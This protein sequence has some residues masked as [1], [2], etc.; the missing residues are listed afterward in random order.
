MMNWAR[1]QLANVTGTPEPIYGPSAIRSIATQA[2]TT[3]FTLLEKDDV[4]WVDMES[5]SMET[6]TFYL[7]A[8]SGHIGIVQVIHSNVVGL[9]RTSQFNTKIFYPKNDPKPH[10][11]STDQLFDVG[12]SEDKF[13]FYASNCAI[14]ISENGKQYT[15]KSTSNENSIVNLT[16]SQI[17]PGFQVGKDGKTLYGTNMSSP[18]GSMRHTFWPRNKVEGL[19]VTK[20]GP[21][22]FKGLCLFVHALQGMKPH[23]A[24]AK[25]NFV[26]FQGPKYTA[27]MMEFT[28][29][30]SY[31]STTVN[32]GGIVHDNE[33]TMASASNFISYTKVRCDEDNNW[34]VPESAKYEWIEKTDKGDKVHAVIEGSLGERSDRIDVMA[35]LPVFVKQI[36]AGAVGTKPYIYQFFVENS[37]LR[38]KNGE[39]EIVE[40]GQLFT[41]ATFISE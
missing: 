40:E 31:G 35:E 34:L 36:V 6:Q 38:I 9:R 20:D 4:K 29:P 11:W 14:E 1:Q 33:I 5:T 26:N 13:N 21:I 8:E 30:K 12:F 37:T 22:N 15:V 24:A 32:V 28:T 17:A 3:P 19:I 41:E 16:I 25:W 7:H 27:I 39:E 2:E 18:W 10:L 23:H